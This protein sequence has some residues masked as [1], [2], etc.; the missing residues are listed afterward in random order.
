MTQR[1]SDLRRLRELLAGRQTALFT[2]VAGDGSLVSRPMALREV[3]AEGQ[4]WFITR[5][6]SGKARE[7]RFNHHVNAGF[8]P[9][10]DETWISVSG[11]ATLLYDPAQV[12][13]LWSPAMQ[14]F[15]PDGPT[16]PDLC[17]IRLEPGRV[18]Y[19]RGPDGLVGK[20]LYFAM[21]AVTGDP[22]VLSEN[23]RMDLRH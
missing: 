8:A 12:A 10:G 23:A 6:G 14:V 20:A 21:A 18:D 11:L 17:L 16:D 15:F 22:H 5:D 13:R 19:W 7:S 3:D 1:S 9:E 2:T 4:L